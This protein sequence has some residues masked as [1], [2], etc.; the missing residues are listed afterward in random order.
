MAADAEDGRAA[1]LSCARARAVGM[2]DPELV[3][4]HPSEDA[5][6]PS[7][8]HVSVSSFMLLSCIA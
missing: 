4:P 8:D 3:C 7:G 5:F 6:S 1:T 2:H